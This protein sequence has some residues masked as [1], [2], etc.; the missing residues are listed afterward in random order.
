MKFSNE[1]LKILT[2]DALKTTLF[3]T[4]AAITQ[5]S[6]AQ[7]T[8]NNKEIAQLK[9]ETNITTETESLLKANVVKDIYDFKTFEEEQEKYINDSLIPHY[10]D[11]TY[12]IQQEGGYVFHHPSGYIINYC[13]EC[14][15]YQLVDTK[16]NVI[17]GSNQAK[18]VL[19]YLEKEILKK[20]NN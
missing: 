19:W 1:K 12:V 4:A 14:R 8:N 7:N 20:Q 2:K 10:G 13:A 18:D 6:S 17:Y 3:L 16:N 15:S 5:R 11:S 9:S